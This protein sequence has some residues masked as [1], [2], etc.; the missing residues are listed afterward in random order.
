MYV[1]ICEDHLVLTI[2]VTKK[3]RPHWSRGCLRLKYA[4]TANFRNEKVTAP[5]KCFLVILTCWMQLISVTKKLRPHWSWGSG[6]SNYIIAI[7]SVTKKL[8]PHWSTHCPC[9]TSPLY[10]YFRNEKVT[11]PLKLNRVI[12]ETWKPLR[13]FRNE[14]VTAPLKWYIS[15]YKIM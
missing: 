6:T 8:R 1:R 3:L 7:I 12:G 15:W 11:A 13:Y 5:L 14:K 10:G 9:F 2:S 4:Q